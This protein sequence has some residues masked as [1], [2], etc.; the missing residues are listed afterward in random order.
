MISAGG[1]WREPGSPD[2][3]SADVLAV[4][5]DD[6]R[7]VKYRDPTLRLRGWCAATGLDAFAAFV[8]V[9]AGS[10]EWRAIRK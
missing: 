6:R 8:Q 9:E 1:R 3:C 10:N 4:P 7:S 2:G 5:R